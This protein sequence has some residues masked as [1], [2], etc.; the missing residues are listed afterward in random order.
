M[1]SKILIIDDSI[2][3]RKVFRSF[4]E[5]RTNFEVYEEAAS[6]LDAMEKARQLSPDLIVMDSSMPVAEGVD[7]GHLL[8][9]MLPEVPIIVYLSR[10]STTAKLGI[11]EFGIQVAA[12]HLGIQRIWVDT[13]V[14]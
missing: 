2:L 3:V 14:N 13:F 4:L 5:S 7:L 10:D 1:L 6:G 8:K 11:L 9:A 12:E